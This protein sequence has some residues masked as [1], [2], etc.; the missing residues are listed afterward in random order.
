MN[1]KYQFGIRKLAQDTATSFNETVPSTDSGLPLTPDQGQPSPMKN[2][3]VN[4][5]SDPYVA[6][7]EGYD[8]QQGVDMQQD[9]GMQPPPQMISAAQSFLGPDVMQSAMQGDTNAMDLL[10][11]TA[12]HVGSTFMNMSQQPPQAQPGMPGGEGAGNPMDQGQPG[13]GQPGM[14][15][16]PQMTSPEEDLA[17]ELVPNVMPPEPGAGP[18]PGA[19]SES[20][21][22][23]EQAGQPAGNDDEQDVGQN[24]NQPG[25]EM[26]DAGTVARLIQLAKA[27]K[28]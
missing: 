10:A 27:G 15:Q 9:T 16:Q 20:V 11:R 14:P 12:A 21:P 7:P 23:N 28:I 22:G 25:T 6:T 17:S 26:V 5:A 19:G 3:I 8:D 18:A 2:T 13:M 24:K 1:K 4:S